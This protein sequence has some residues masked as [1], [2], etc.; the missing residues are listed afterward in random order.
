MCQDAGADVNIPGS[1]T[2]WYGQL[3]R[4][5]LQ[6]GIADVLRTSGWPGFWTY[7][8]RG[9]R[10][11]SACV[12]IVDCGIRAARRD[13]YRLPVIPGDYV[14]VHL[15]T[16]TCSFKTIAVIASASLRCPIGRFRA[17]DEVVAN[18]NAISPIWSGVSK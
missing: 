10:A 5:A 16:E 8:H 13:R 9:A 14:A 11:Q 15:K 12:V 1:K 18:D 2:A 3:C 6:D 17:D 4:A 7:V